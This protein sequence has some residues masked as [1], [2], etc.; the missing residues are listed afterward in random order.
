LVT[1]VRII[2]LG[3]K[4]NYTDSEEI[5][6]ILRDRGY[7][8]IGDFSPADL[9]I[10]NTCVVT[11]RADYQS[12]QAIRRAAKA[13][14][15][16]PIVVTGCAASAFPERVKGETS[17]AAVVPPGRTGAFGDMVGSLIG[18]A[19]G[20]SPP[21]ARAMRTR[22]FLKI[23]EG[24]DARCAYCIVPAARGPVRSVPPKAVLS[25][26]ER[27][28]GRGFLEVVLVGTHLG[29]YGGD[30]GNGTTLAGLL[31]E[32]A[33][34][35]APL[36]LRLSSIE[37]ME[38]TGALLSVME[39]Y[40]VIAPHLH[41]PLQSGD[42]RILAA[43][44]RPY[45]AKTFERI[46]RDAAARLS[47]PGLGVDVIVG[48]PGEGEREFAQTVD[49]IGRLPIS[50]LHVFPF[51]RR[52]GTPAFSMDRQVPGGTKKER[53]RLLREIGTHKKAEYIGRYI[54]K[55]VSVLVEE[56][57]D[58]IVRGKSENYIEVYLDGG[59]DDINRFVRVTLDRPFRDGA[60]G[61]RDD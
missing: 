24:C 44:G 29:R 13:S 45:D 40:P 10:V 9:S 55:E 15:G 19:A 3:C 56:S 60:Y 54:G 49:L 30:M 35:Y 23:Q 8:V 47:D 36:R 57:T 5:G 27:L 61:K 14:P 33:A 59:P 17:V 22:A 28:A 37:P 38:L 53:A 34:A 11:G 42:D 12:R 41:V 7:R 20:G 51:S 48:L 31:G 6:T 32:I 4:V 2:T 26:I 16:A 52:P 43:M 58:G 18:P 39:R 21:P 46:V 25:N 1:T 50:Y